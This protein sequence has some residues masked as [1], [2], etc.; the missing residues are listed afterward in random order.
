MISTKSRSGMP[1]AINTRLITVE[2]VKEDT[3]EDLISPTKY[4]NETKQKVSTFRVPK[5]HES[6]EIF[7]QLDQ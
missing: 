4:S 1:A 2:T 6:E 7:A 5:R 3:L